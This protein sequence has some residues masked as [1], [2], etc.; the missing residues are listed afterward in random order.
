MRP[1][2]IHDRRLQDFGELDQ[3]LHAVRRARHAVDDDHRL[4]RADEQL[5]GF[6]RW[7]PDRPAAASSC[8]SF[9]IAEACRRLVNRLFLQLGVE[10]EHHRPVGRRHRDLVGAHERLREML[11]ATPACRPIW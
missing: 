4:L 2:L 11:R 6:A 1:P 9:G 8:V 3:Q 10:R 5:R 7:R